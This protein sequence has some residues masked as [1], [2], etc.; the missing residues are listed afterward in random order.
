M[1]ITRRAFLQSAIWG[2]CV[3]PGWAAVQPRVLHFAQVIFD[4]RRS[5]ALVFAETARRLGASTHAIYGDV[6]DRWFQHVR[7]QWISKRI[8]VAG[9]TDFRALF[10]L[11]TMAADA[12]LHPVLR[13]HHGM[14]GESAA[15]E[16]FG[17]Q[18]YRLMSDERLA[19]C[20]ECWAP[21]VARLI[22]SLPQGAANASRHHGSLDEANM[23]TL[24]SMGLVTWV[25]A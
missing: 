1:S 13:I 2:A 22:L 3:L 12:G 24:G 18:A 8:P 14:R 10:L 9:I 20:G 17:A 11:Q 16:A 19:D 5:H 7:R 15:H 6:N 23:R 25:M 21:E 4:A